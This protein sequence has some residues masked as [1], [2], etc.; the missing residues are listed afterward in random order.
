MAQLFEELDE[1]GGKE[2]IPVIL[3][4]IIPQPDMQ[5]LTDM[6]VKRI[7]TPKDYDLMEVMNQI[8]D[9]VLEHKKSE[10]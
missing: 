6:G 3:G 5:G 2:S 7:F 9:V 1:Q 4:G 8:M 10:A